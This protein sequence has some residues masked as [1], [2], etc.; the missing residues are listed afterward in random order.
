MLSCLEL[1]VLLEEI[2]FTVLINTVKFEALLK[3]LPKRKSWKGTKIEQTPV[4]ILAD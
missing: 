2:N 3:C 4:I 1:G